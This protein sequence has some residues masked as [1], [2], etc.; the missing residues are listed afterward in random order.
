MYLDTEKYD[1]TVIFQPHCKPKCARSQA[2]ISQYF[3]NY[4]FK[5]LETSALHIKKKYMFRAIQKTRPS[6][7]DTLSRGCLKIC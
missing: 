4:S 6:R 5:K 2:K 7:C 1:Q 3:A